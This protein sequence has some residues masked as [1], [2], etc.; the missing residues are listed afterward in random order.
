MN[1]VL[2]RPPF[3]SKFRS[4]ARWSL[5]LSAILA[6]QQF[7][8]AADIIV[9]NNADTGNGTLRQALQFNEALGGGNTI[10]FS[11]IV[12]GT[13]TLTN[14]LG[15]LLITKDVSIVGPGS[16]LL[17]ISGNN[18]RRVF[19]LTNNALVNISGL[20]I[21]SGYTTDPGAGLRQDSGDL[22]LS[23]CT[24][25][26]N[27]ASF[28]F[29]GGISL[30]GTVLANRCTFST[31]SGLAGGAVYA[32]GTFKAI[33][34]TMI[35]NQ[36]AGGAA[37][38]SNGGSLLL[39]NCTITKNSAL[40][41]T[42]SSYG[43]G[44]SLPSGTAILRN[45]IV[46]G[47]S[48]YDGFPD[49]Y[50]A[51][52]SVGFNLIGAIN[53]STGWGALGDQIGTTNSYLNP[54][55]G[56]LQDNGGQT[57]SVAPQSGSPAIDQG[58]SSGIL[59]DQRGHTRPYTNSTI[60]SS[61]L[62]GDRADVG[63]VELSPVTLVVSN[64]NN[65]GVG[66]LRQTIFDASPV[67]GDT[68]T[69]SPN[70]FGTIALTNG[71]L[72]ISKPLTIHG[73][74]TLPI[75]VSGNN[76]SR[77]FHIINNSKVSV[78]FLTVSNG[79]SSG[80][81]AGFYNDFGC[82]LV[83]SN[84][85]VVANASGENGGGVANNGSFAAYNCT[86]ASNRASFTGGAIYT[87]AG[88]VALLN[89][90][91]I[92]NSTTI[93]H[94]GGLCNYSPAAGTSNYIAGTLVARNSAVGHSDL[95][96]VFTS[97]GYNLIGQIDY[98]I[99]SLGAAAGIATSGLTNGA[100]HDQVGSTNAP[101]DPKIGRLQNNGGATPT[102][103]LLSN[104]PAIDKGISNGLLLDQRGAP[105]PFDFASITNSAGGDGSDVGAFELGRPTL[106]VQKA[107][108]NIIV[109]WPSYYGDFVLQSTTN[110]SGANNWAIVPGSP[111]IVGNLFNL[112][113]SS[114]AG[115]KLYRLENQ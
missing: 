91:I 20:R 82:A 67:D 8:G 31:N 13:I 9:A 96:G 28:S 61:P 39:T 33:N 88:P 70:L 107:A 98:S 63:A 18:S 14:P 101:I 4:L 53:G 68:I 38:F 55:L 112:T 23:D 16:K 65:G 73:S 105:R 113:N 47:N 26:G 15:E 22:V 45:S 50:G 75:V 58:H 42:S 43:G 87:Y 11:N 59:H 92:S 56:P 97:G 30:L 109:S 99:P 78:S 46:A 100:N 106:A 40:Q 34:C 60:V 94:G 83:L 89:C 102:I 10:L 103:S 25:S 76:L 51:F 5:S 115:I 54:L 110:L 84:C 81:G 66:S 17:T 12:T 79:A 7:V 93:A 48:A 104:S 86:F 69:F 1:S 21:A 27:S 49:C 90:T 85:A 57:V 24:I 2:L 37:I 114:V 111:V 80:Q 72:L 29:G 108:T 36:A 52:S 44:I 95:I 3:V 41:Y 77:V 62:G 19:H 64:T 6:L 32:G 71:E 74:T 35:G